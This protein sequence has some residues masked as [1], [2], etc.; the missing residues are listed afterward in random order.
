MS[1]TIWKSSPTTRR[2]PRWHWWQVSWSFCS[3]SAGAA[4]PASAWGGFSSWFVPLNSISVFA[5][6]EIGGRL[7]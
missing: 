2:L 1:T 6:G 7:C 3:A 4:E 5:N